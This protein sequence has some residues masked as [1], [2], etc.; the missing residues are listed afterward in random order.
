MSYVLPTFNL[1][2]SIWRNANFG[3]GAADVF[4]TANLSTARRVSGPAGDDGLITQWI[5]FPPGTDVRDSYHGGLQDFLE[6]PTGSSRFYEVIFVDDIGLGFSNE[7]RFAKIRPVTTWPTP[8]PI[9]HGPYPPPPS[10]DFVEVLTATP[11]IS[12]GAPFSLAFTMPS[13]GMAVLTYTFSKGLLDVITATIDA[14]GVPGRWNNGY[15]LAGNNII[16]QTSQV[17]LPAGVHTLAIT[18]TSLLPVTFEIKVT[19]VNATA[20]IALDTVTGIGTIAPVA[21]VGF[22][23]DSLNPE[24]LL[25]AF[26]GEPW[27]TVPS[28]SAPFTRIGADLVIGGLGARRLVTVCYKAILAGTY[29]ATLGGGFPGTN[30]AAGQ[31]GFGP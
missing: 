14:V 1:N 25:A 15:V 22:P 13:A 12:F 31:A 26:M 9:G 19:Y 3:V 30:W 21:V 29:N 23:P 17:H 7:H 20:G 10:P 8:Y 4:S 2:V 11:N 16:L 18:D 24:W 27:G 6:A 28:I 5:M